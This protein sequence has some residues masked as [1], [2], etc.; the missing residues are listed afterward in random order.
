MKKILI[1]LITLAFS[2]AALAQNVGIGTTSPSGKLHVG[3]G[4]RFG[5]ADIGSVFFQ[6]GN[7]IGSARDWKIYVPMTAGNLAF[8][9]MGFDNLNNGMSSDAMVIQFGTGNIG[10]GTTNPGAKL[11]INGLLKITDG[12]QGT[13]K[14]LTSD[15]NGLSSWVTPKAPAFVFGTDQS[16]GNFD[17]IGLG[18]SSAGFPR[19]SAVV[20]FNCE[21]GSIAFSIRSALP[22]T[23]INLTLWKSSGIG[24]SPVAT[25]LTATISNGT[26]Q[27]FA[28][29]TGTIPLL[30][31]DLISVQINWSTGGA[32][33]NG[34]TATV[35]Y[36]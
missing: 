6:S 9:D 18:T 2:A 14:V 3:G 26:T 11:E 16:L 30:Q 21:I 34:A 15:A 23:N 12:S 17:F 32:L 20:P 36:K 7:S 31:G 25:P 5:V 4:T 10:I 19:N 33:S 8:R 1:V 28:A 22:N 29:A 13:G 24:G 27:I 35:T